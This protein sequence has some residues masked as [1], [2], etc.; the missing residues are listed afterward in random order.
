MSIEYLNGD[1]TTPIGDGTKLLVHICNDVGKWGKGFVLAVSHRWPAPEKEY[2]AAFTR[3]PQPVL[4]DVQFIDVGSGVYVANLIGQH[5]LTKGINGEPP[6]RYEAVRQGLEKVALF[7]K[8]H[9]ATVHMPRI[10]CGLAGGS[11]FK[12]E[13][14][15]IQTLNGF[16]VTVYDR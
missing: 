15:I 5:G 1:A 9:A 10:G 14:I 12:I 3:S 4:G 13:P 16:S 8:Q 2:R 6:I 7:A 11:W